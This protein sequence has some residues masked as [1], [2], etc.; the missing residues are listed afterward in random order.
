[1]AVEELLGLPHESSASL[2][3]VVPSDADWYCAPFARTVLG[4]AFDAFVHEGRLDAGVV[5]SVFGVTAGTVRRWARTA[6]PLSRRESIRSLISVPES[7]FE[8]EAVQ[9]RNAREA[10][11]TLA[12]RGV[13]TREWI[14]RGWTKPHVMYR[15]YFPRLGVWI[16]RVA[17]FDTKTP[18]RI[19][20][21]AGGGLIVGKE[22][23]PTYFEAQVAKF[24]LLRR[25]ERWRVTIPEGEGT[26]GVHRIQGRASAVLN[27]SQL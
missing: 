14:S 15:V 10:V 7:V 20:A 27:G 23:F 11:A 4:L 26:S 5:A 19:T 16:P 8:Q 21:G 1:M 22:Y 25:C 13:Q 18:S 17:R 3:V 2:P 9:L 6:L 12:L 24:E